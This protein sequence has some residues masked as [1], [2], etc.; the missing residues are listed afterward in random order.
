MKPIFEFFIKLCI[1]SVI[2][3]GVIFAALNP[4]SVDYHSVFLAWI[5]VV[6]NAVAVYGRWHLG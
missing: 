6:T 5:M 4:G 2:L 1:L 3:W